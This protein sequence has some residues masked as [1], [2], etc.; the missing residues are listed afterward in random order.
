MDFFFLAFNFEIIIESQAVAKAVA[1][2]IDYLT[3]FPSMVTHNIALV[4]II[5]PMNP[6]NQVH[7]DAPPGLFPVQT[8]PSPWTSRCIYPYLLKI[9]SKKL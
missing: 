6:Q 8:D 4:S 9:S 7:A 5:S 1:N 2:P 3:L